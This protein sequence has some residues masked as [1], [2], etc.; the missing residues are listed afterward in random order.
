MWRQAISP[1]VRARIEEL[2]LPFNRWGLDPYGV[3]KEHL[4]FFLSSLGLAYHHYFRVRTFNIQNVPD[5]GPVMLIS[6]HSGGL[7]TDGG[8]ILA[9]MFFDHDPPRLA[10]GMV[11]KFAQNWPVLSPLFSRVGQL[12]G[13]PEHAKRL[14]SDGRV[15][16][17]FPEGARGTGKLYRDRYQLVRF[18]T[19]FMRIALEMNAPIVPLAFIGGEEAI[20]TIHHSK[21]LAKIFKA[22]YVPITPYIVPFPL[23]VHCE[24]HY[25]KPMRFEGSGAEPDDV[26][27]GYVAQVKEQVEQL[28]ADGRG[29]RSRNIA[30]EP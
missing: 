20:P 19:G 27:E 21:T 24:V 30:E 3:S 4:G 16:M 14:L 2:D 22:P 6:N 9:S 29:S 8:M 5:T 1:D 11:E 13:L 28:I 15:L 7:P 25:G 23:P 18:G 26:I 17:V 12:P 10:H